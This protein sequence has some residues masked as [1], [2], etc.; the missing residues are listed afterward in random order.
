MGPGVMQADAVKADFSGAVGALV[1]DPSVGGMGLMEGGGSGS[2]EDSFVKIQD[3]GEI[4]PILQVEK[5]ENQNW[6]GPNNGLPKIK[7]IAVSPIKEVFLHFEYPFVY[8][9]QEEPQYLPKPGCEPYQGGGGNPPPGP[10]PPECNGPGEENPNYLDP[11]KMENGFQCQIFKV[12]GGNLDELI[13]GSGGSE[14]ECLDN[15]HFIDSWQANR[16]SVFQFDDEGNV[17]YPGSSP[18]SGGR[19]VVYKRATD[20]NVKEMINANICVQDFLVTANGGMFYTGS[21]SC[22]GSGGASGGFFRYVAPEGGALREIARDWWNFV[23]EAVAG[24]T[25]DKAVFFGPDPRSATTASWNSAC[26]FRYDPSAGSSAQQTISDVIT[27][28]SDIWSWMNMTRNEDITTYGQG[29]NSP[30]RTPTSAWKTEFARRCESS[31]Q[32][33]AGGG[34]Q[35]NAIKQDSQG[36]VYVIGQVRKKKAGKVSCNVQIKGAHCVDKDGIP[37]LPAEHADYADADSCTGGGG[38]WKDDGNGYCRAINGASTRDLWE[39][40]TA[41]ACLATNPSTVDMNG[42]D[43]VVTPAASVKWFYTQNTDYNNVATPICAE[44][45][46]VPTGKRIW[47]WDVNSEASTDGT[48]VT[49]TTPKFASDWWNCSPESS[50]SNNGGGG[51]QWLEEYKGLAQVN[52]ST[53]SLELRSGVDEQAIQLWLINDVPY[54]S[55]YNTTEGKYYLKRYYNNQVQT[56]AENFET[57][58]LSE[59]NAAGMFYYDGLNFETNE[60]S[61][62]T[63]NKSTFEM[64]KKTGL[65]GQ[66]KMIV[67]LPKS[68]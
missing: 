59:G 60:Y 38:T 28:G 9:S 39:K 10:M 66:V 22:G 34:S 27:C 54:Y 33:F 4:A 15:V 68:N 47:D 18:N 11:W 17:Y 1:L 64:T 30:D 24:A 51:D 43:P 53:K 48:T 63:I 55:S 61:F 46:N 19:M 37:H 13:A 62:G 29:F 41:D 45:S 2:G 31:G 20:G 25:T 35:I 12:K 58:N 65:T 40:T 7:T 21:S 14:L 36:N 42:A 6:G 56:V 67:K 52:E 49:Y 8:R 50:A 57:Y 26:L 3:D 44:T 23:Y 16:N 32:V 5:A